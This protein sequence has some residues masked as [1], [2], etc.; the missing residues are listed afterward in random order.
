MEAAER[1]ASARTIEA[2]GRDLEDFA[3]YISGADSIAT[4]SS[5]QLRG[6]L[7]HMRAQGMAARTAAR[8]LS[9]LRQFFKFL[10]AEGLRGD[11][12]TAV[13]DSPRLGRPLP[14]FLT[15]SEVEALLAAARA[16]AAPEDLRRLAL[17]ELLYATG[18]RVSELVGLPIAA[19]RALSREG[20]AT[21]IVRGK[22][23]RER[24]VPVGAAARA[25]VLA[26]GEVRAH[27]LGA[28]KTSPWLF[29]SDAREIGRAHV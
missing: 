8:R 28:N 18:L 1:G 12:P 7:D 20:N 24:L 26:Y 29:P 16:N 25:A 21:L 5:A 4:A 10:Y 14:K 9:C 23:E 15:E 19:I 11:D 6:Y 13:L 2:Y 3:E 17:V 22:G 27:F